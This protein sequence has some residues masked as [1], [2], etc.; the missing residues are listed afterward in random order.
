MVGELLLWS[1][2][3]AYLCLLVVALCFA[4]AESN[5]HHTREIMNAVP[6]GS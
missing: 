1:V 3:C 5:F 4:L 6:D 2:V